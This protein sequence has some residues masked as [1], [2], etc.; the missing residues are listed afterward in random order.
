VLT[1]C[2][3]V[4]SDVSNH[5]PTPGIRARISVSRCPQISKTCLWRPA[6]RERTFHFRGGGGG[7][8]LG[9]WLV[10]TFV[11]NSRWNGLLGY[12]FGGNRFYQRIQTQ[13][14]WPFN[15]PA[16]FRFHGFW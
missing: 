1:V 8:S 7:R 9:S 2:S 5:S 11:N 6:S 4:I 15:A 10:H 14:S 12:V 13:L 3:A 16:V